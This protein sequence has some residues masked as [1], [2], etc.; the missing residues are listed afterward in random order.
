MIVITTPKNDFYG[1]RRN[2]LIVEKYVSTSVYEFVIHGGP[3]DKQVGTMGA[4]LT[5]I[6][7]IYYIHCNALKT[8]ENKVANR[9]GFATPRIVVGVLM[10]NLTPKIA[11]HVIIILTFLH[12]PRLKLKQLIEMG[13]VHVMRGITQT[14]LNV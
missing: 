4:T 3:K 5:I 7:S 13:Q 8:P 2:D 12:H 9:S 6:S 14:K 1:M 10:C 11:F